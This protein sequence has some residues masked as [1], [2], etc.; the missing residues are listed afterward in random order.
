MVL[1]S[2]GIAFNFLFVFF[3]ATFCV[4]YQTGDIVIDF[5]DKTK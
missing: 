1:E 3:M 5:L 4:V 2:M